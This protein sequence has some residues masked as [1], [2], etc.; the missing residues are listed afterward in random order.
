M[1]LE[2]FSQWIC[3][4][5]SFCLLHKKC[6]HRL[7][8]FD[9]ELNKHPPSSR[10]CSFFLNELFLLKVMQKLPIKTLKRDIIVNIDN[11]EQSF[12]KQNI[13]LFKVN[14]RNT[15]VRCELRSK[16]KIKIPERSNWRHSGVFI[17]TFEYI[18]H[19]LFYCFCC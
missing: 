5:L 3:L 13:H 19:T 1:L 14:Y 6:K 7:R 2:Y 18:S 15:S 16:L 8:P 11:F 17:I 12:K 4:N 9:L 10:K